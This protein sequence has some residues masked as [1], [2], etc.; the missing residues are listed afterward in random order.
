VSDGYLRGDPGADPAP[1]DGATAEVEG[2]EDAQVMKDDVVHRFQC[3]IVCCFS[4]SGVSR[5]DQEARFRQRLMK[6][7]RLGLYPVKVG[8]AMKIENGAAGTDFREPDVI[9]RDAY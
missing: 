6:R 5:G 3:F 4:A 2:I 8:D 1:D 9:T 7:H